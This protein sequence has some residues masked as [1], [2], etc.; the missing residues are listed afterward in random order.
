MKFERDEETGFLKIEG[1][2]RLVEMMQNGQI[3]KVT[4]VKNDG[5]DRVLYCTLKELEKKSTDDAEKE[6]KKKRKTNGSVLPV[7]DVQKDVYRSFRI[8]RVKNVEIPII[9]DP[10][11]YRKAFAS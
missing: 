8:D 2:W 9:Q 10:E 3:I 6:K 5:T 4:F 11:I 1:K 7:F